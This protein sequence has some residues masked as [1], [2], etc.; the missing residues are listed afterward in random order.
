MPAVELPRDEIQHTQFEHEWWYFFARVT[1][2]ATKIRFHYTSA[3]MRRGIAWVSYARWWP[4]GEDPVLRKEMHLGPTT[5]SGTELVV[6]PNDNWRVRLAAGRSTHRLGAIG[7][8]HFSDDST[9]A[10]LHTPSGDGGIRSYGGFNEMAWYSW[11]RS[12]V[13]GQ[14]A[15]TIG[16]EGIVEGIGWMEHQWGNTDFTRLRWR[17]LP[18]LLADRTL[19]AYHY[20]HEDVPGAETTEVA[21]LVDGEARVLPDCTLSPLAPGRGPT[22]ITG[23]GLKLDCRPTAEGIVDLRFPGVPRFCEAPTLVF[24]AEGKEVGIAMTEYHPV[25]A[26]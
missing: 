25:E 23:G 11:P 20:A 1:Q 6:E 16:A 26:T 18:I 4:D 3:L 17:Y 24:D 5:H 8:L 7:A 15:G 21:E 22:S 10:F 19:I 2:P 14:L 9:G 12:K 13:R